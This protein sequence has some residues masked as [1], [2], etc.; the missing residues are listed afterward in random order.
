MREQDRNVDGVG[1]HRDDDHRAEHLVDA[2][3]L[4]EGQVEAHAGDRDRS[5]QQQVVAAEAQPP[6]DGGEEVERDVGGERIAEVGDVAQH[7]VV[8]QQ[9]GAAPC[10]RRRRM[11]AHLAGVEDGEQRIADGDGE[12]AVGQRAELADGGQ[13]GQADQRAHQAGAAL[14]L[15]EA[16]RRLGAEPRLERQQPLEERAAPQRAV[17]WGRIGRVHGEP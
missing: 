2:P 8:D 5:G 16:D 10:A 6:S 13:P 1:E 3:V 14:P 17:N 15:L 9:R 7:Q 11:Q 4:A 12:D